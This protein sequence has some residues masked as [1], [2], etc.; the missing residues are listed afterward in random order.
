M[1]KKDYGA[2]E[3]TGA[4]PG[5]NNG[6]FED[7]SADIARDNSACNGIIQNGQWWTIP[8][9]CTAT[10]FW[11][12]P[13][14]GWFLGFIPYPIFI[15]NQALAYSLPSSITAKGFWLKQY[16]FTGFIPT[17]EE[18]LSGIGRV[19]SGFPA[20]IVKYRVHNPNSYAIQIEVHAS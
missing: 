9:K 6:T 10:V 4:Q 5:S 16:I 15:S 2:P 19:Y 1:R 3:S 14:I 8:P 20:F 18:T 12:G 11:K 17:D 7:K 13:A